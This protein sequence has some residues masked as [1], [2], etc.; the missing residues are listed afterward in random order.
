[1]YPIKSLKRRYSLI[2]SI[3]IFY[4]TICTLFFKTHDNIYQKSDSNQ[5]DPEEK[6][7]TYLPH[8]G[9]HNQRISFENSIF[10]AYFLNRTLIL[11]PILFFNGL[12]HIYDADSDTLYSR[13]IH[14]NSNSN[15]FTF[16]KDHVCK[17]VQ[18]TLYHWEELMDMRW[19]KNHIKITYRRE[20]NLT[21]LLDSLNITHENQYIFLKDSVDY[22]YRFYDNS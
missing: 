15:N 21:F 7:L 18:Y 10:L 2:F 9:F 14:L 11:P 5:S 16:C 1:M 8:S 4:T 6:F 22:H 3:M 19:I 20:F 17:N 12:R 13:L